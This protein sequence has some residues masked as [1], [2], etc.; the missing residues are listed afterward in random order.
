[1]EVLQA[2]LSVSDNSSSLF[3][4]VDEANAMHYLNWTETVISSRPAS[5][6]RKIIFE[7]SEIH[8]MSC[9]E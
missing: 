1:M 8:I 6:F 5:W 3:H 9:G 7:V 4:P 2:S